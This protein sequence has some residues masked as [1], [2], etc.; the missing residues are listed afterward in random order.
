MSVLDVEPVSL[1]ETVVGD[2]RSVNFFN[3]RLLAGEDLSSEQ[4]TQRAERRLLGEA[5]G[6][7]VAFGLEVHEDPA[8]SSA[9]RPVVTVE[10]GLAISRDGQTLALGR[11]TDVA[12]AS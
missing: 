8:R 7:G 4:Q 6:D 12:L 11:R 9:A 2:I 5:V 1:L 3:G 10:P